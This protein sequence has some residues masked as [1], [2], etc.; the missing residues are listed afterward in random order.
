MNSDGK[1][2]TEFT[3]SGVITA[4]SN[5]IA[6]HSRFN[7]V[8]EAKRVAA[9][10]PED[11]AIV[12][13]GGFGLGYV[14]EALLN[15]APNR[16]L[17]IAEADESIPKRAAAVRDIGPLINN[18]QVQFVLGKDVKNIGSYLTGGPVGSKISLII[19]RPSERGNP[20]W[21]GS[22]RQ[23]VKSI[24]NRREINARTL[25]RFG[26]LWVRNIIANAPILPKALPLL[27]WEGKLRNIPALIVAGGPSTEIVLPELGD[28][29]KS[30]LII[31]V[32]TAVSAVS[33]VGVRPDIIAAVDPQYWN[34]RHLDWCTEGLDD[35]PI[36]AE[37]ATHPAVFRALSGRPLL[38]RTKFPLGTLLE[39]AAGIQGEL[40]SGGSVATA[41]WELAR[42]LG[43]RPLSI[44]GLDLGFPDGRTHFSGSFSQERPHLYSKR[45]LPAE[46]SF[47]RSLYD[48]SAYYAKSYRDE[49][50]LTNLR[51]D[52]YAS[53]FAESISTQT[54]D[55]IPQT[56]GDSGRRI[57][58]M[59]T[60]GI[61]E[62]KKLPNVRGKIDAILAELLD[63]PINSACA[64]NI[65]EVIRGVSEELD[66][67]LL[68]AK[69]GMKFAAEAEQLIADGQNPNPQ[70]AAMGDIDEH[71]LAMKGRE[72]VSF[73]IQPIILELSSSGASGKPLEN[74][75]RLYSEIAKS[76]SYHRCHLNSTSHDIAAKNKAGQLTVR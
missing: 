55:R 72:L 15:A 9:S 58:G 12:V 44:A 41:A 10:I 59:T 54:L 2:C 20:N 23:T 3:R 69:K 5:D 60:V 71:L 26:R 74:S 37:A 43:C 73:L 42:L 47:F 28:I 24:Q 34:T 76:A 19:W 11:S 39:D 6:L 21:Y 75:R 33:R 32:D 7:P 51:M 48:A 14:A 46:Q 49:S 16:P 1:W 56:V 27:S 67:L 62:L 70:L 64:S 68:L 18:P 45:T 13:L 52:V 65:Q 31:V 25:E 63:T 35:C 61:P 17:I 8:Q 4:F 50:L 57:R 29:S 38:S 22:L 40:R 53:W 36:L 30:H 66:E